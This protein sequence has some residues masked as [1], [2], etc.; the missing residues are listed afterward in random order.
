MI[1]DVRQAR[2][3]VA[4]VILAIALAFLPSAAAAEGWIDDEAEET[5]AGDMDHHESESKD[6]DD[7]TTGSRDPDE[8]T[9]EAGTMAGREAQ[10][11]DP[12]G[13]VTTA[14][15][16]DQHEES[17]EDLTDLETARPDPGFEAID[18]PG[19]AEWEPTTDPNVL[20]AR[21]NLLRAEKRARAA[22][23]A[24]GDMMQRDYPR[25]QARIRIV[26]ERDAA[27]KGLEEAKQAL[28]AADNAS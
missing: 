24:Y 5:T 18:V 20:I 11:Q 8:M 12:D 4:G 19:Q 28:E 23:T 7:M 22:R 17:A 25:G 21:Q 16:M 10:S 9:T 1:E 6:P 15:D 3:T 13:M 26:N 2:P 27:M 14:Q